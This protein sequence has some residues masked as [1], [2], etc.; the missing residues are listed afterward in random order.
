MKTN[1]DLYCV[2]GKVCGLLLAIFA[3]PGNQIYLL[4][5]ELK[6]CDFNT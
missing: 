2:L 4:G 5:T 3:I 1:I 6:G